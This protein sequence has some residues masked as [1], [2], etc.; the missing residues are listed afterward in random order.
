MSESRSSEVLRLPLRP[1]RLLFLEEASCHASRA[2][3][4]PGGEALAEKNCGLQPPTRIT[5]LIMWMSQTGCGFSKHKTSDDWSPNQHLTATSWNILSQTCSM[6]YSWI[7]DPR[8]GGRRWKIILD[9]G[10]DVWEWFVMQRY[11]TDADTIISKIPISNS[12]QI[13]A[14]QHYP[15]RKLIYWGMD[16]CSPCIL[17]S[18]CLQPCGG[19]KY[20]LRKGPL[21][22]RTSSAP[23]RWGKACTFQ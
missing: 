14:H 20:F 9:L 22:P 3:K 11:I 18:A 19:L 4:Q 10:H 8:N 21:F 2:L 23:I 16:L 15:E 13:K 6:G 12:W 17:W 1:L 5:L 7:P